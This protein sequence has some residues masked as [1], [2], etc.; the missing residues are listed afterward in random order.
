LPPTLSECT[1]F[2]IMSSRVSLS[3]EE[4]DSL[5]REAHDA[6]EGDYVPVRTT[7][8][9]KKKSFFSGGGKISPPPK[10]NRKGKGRAFRNTVFILITLL[11]L[12]FGL[13]SAKVLKVGSNVL[14]Q[15]RSIFAQL[16]D[17]I[18]PGQ[19]NLGGEKDGQINILLTAIGGK[20]HEGE[21]LADTIMVAM[22]RPQEK[23]IALLSIP[24]DLYVRLPESNAF[25]KI[26]AVHAYK[27]NVKAGEGPIYLKKKVEEV[28]GVPINY[29]VRVDFTAFKRV[30][31]EL[32]GIEITVQN[33]FYDYW[34]KISFPAGKEIMNGDRALAFSRARYVEG[35]EGGDFKR[36]AR[37][38]QVLMAIRNKALSANTAFDLRAVSGILDALGDNVVT[39]FNLVE[40]K[41]LFEIVREVKKDNIQSAVLSTGPNGL[42]VGGTEILDGKPAS[43]LSP[44]AGRENYSEIRNFAQHIFENTQTSPP[45]SS[46]PEP[47]QTPSSTPEPSAS[48]SP[49]PSGNLASE[50]ATVEVRNGTNITGLASKAAAKLRG[51]KLNVTGIGNAVKRDSTKTIVIDQTDGK[52]TNSLQTILSSLDVSSA[53]ELPTSEK[54][55]KA[56]FLIILGSDQNPS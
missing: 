43:I 33:G 5:L 2:M 26:N 18:L 9:P 19:K 55:S 16:A 50:K 48:P 13:F 41:R 7:K 56:D 38:Q 35:P 28:T 20:G 1:L 40:I 15:E 23:K 6:D 30:V 53:S 32:G 27:E 37:Q 54:S 42:L 47:T 51:S 3:S 12:V 49:T 21:N 39:N 22:I 17:L 31:D 44:R 52:K 4:R 24:R 34:H 14:N 11:I 29:Y 25:T 46:T 45:E 36:A 10:K 8:K